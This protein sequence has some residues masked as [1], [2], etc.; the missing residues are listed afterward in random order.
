MSG[1]QCSIQEVQYK[2]EEE[3]LSPPQCPADQVSS[4]RNPEWTLCTPLI[5]C[6]REQARHVSARETP[7][8]IT[9]TY[10]S[11]GPCHPRIPPM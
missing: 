8:G 11:S 3:P 7:A 6:G 10:Y 4:K 9:D 2:T 5:S 1:S